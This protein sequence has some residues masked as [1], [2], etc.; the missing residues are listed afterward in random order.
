MSLLVTLPLEA[1]VSPLLIPRSTPADAKDNR[2]DH[3]EDGGSSSNSTDTFKSSRAF[4][5]FCFEDYAWRVYHE[6]LPSKDPLDRYRY[7]V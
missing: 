7:R 3:N 2:D 1:T 4:N 5:S 6:R